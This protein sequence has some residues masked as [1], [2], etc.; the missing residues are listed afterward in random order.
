[1]SPI[2]EEIASGGASGRCS[3]CYK[4]FRPCDRCMPTF[5]LGSNREGNGYLAKLGYDPPDQYAHHKKARVRL[6]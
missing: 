3:V 1:M 4:S 2:A 6:S 5:A